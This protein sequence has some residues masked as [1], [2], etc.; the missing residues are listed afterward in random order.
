MT[1]GVVSCPEPLAAEAGAEILLHGG[2]AADAA[3]ATAL[4]ALGRRAERTAYG[5]RVVAAR[6][7]PATGAL[8]GASDPRGGG[9]LAIV[10]EP[11]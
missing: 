8:D 2:N 11:A 6:R 7:D 4:A 10:A 1:A 5:G 3:I 9:G